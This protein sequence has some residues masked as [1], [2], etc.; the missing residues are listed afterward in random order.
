M[1]YN[2]L[3]IDD[4]RLTADWTANLL[5]LGGH[6]VLISLS[7]RTAMRFLNEVIPD[8]LFL[9]IN[10]PGIDG[11][12]VCRYLRRDPYTAEVPIVIVSANSEQ[13][14]K[15]AAAAA[16]AN[17]YLVKPAL[18]DDLTGVLGKIFSEARA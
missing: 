17:D 13:Y 10:M 8:I 11:L 7:P 9:D 14:Y 16:G 15:D 2:I 6:T 5:R 3:V 4:N 1:L 12:E 18:V